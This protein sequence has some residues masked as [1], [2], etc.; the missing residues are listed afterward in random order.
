MDSIYFQTAEHLKPGERFTRAAIRGL[1]EELGIQI[2]D[3]PLKRIKSL[4]F[5]S[6]EYNDGEIKDNEWKECWQCK[7]IFKK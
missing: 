3:K 2:G 7:F 6:F 5:S 1:K 4:Y